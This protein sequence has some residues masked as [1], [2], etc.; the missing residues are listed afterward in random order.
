[1]LKHKEPIIA[2]TPI[3]VTNTQLSIH[4]GSET[5]SS[6]NSTVSYLFLKFIDINK[7]GITFINFFSE[8]IAVINL[9]SATSGLLHLPTSFKILVNGAVHVSKI[10]CKRTLSCVNKMRPTC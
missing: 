7:V 6:M 5:N 9:L 8:T 2:I 4:R 1:M 3:M 10:E